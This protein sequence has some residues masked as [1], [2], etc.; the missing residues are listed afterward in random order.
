MVLS[1]VTQSVCF[2]DC[3]DIWFSK[4]LVGC[5]YCFGCTNLRKKKYHIFNKPY[6]KEGYFKELVR[7]NLES[8]G[9][10]EELR[11]RVETEQL[12]F[13]VKFIHGQH[14][15]NVLGDYLDHC[16]DTRESRQR[17]LQVSS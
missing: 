6:A 2:S 17:A 3:V 8:F 15:I 12:K 4:N 11:K 13:P 5:Q 9:T 16:K 14:D 10:V 7:Y 1:L